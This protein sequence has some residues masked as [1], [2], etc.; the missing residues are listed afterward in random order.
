[1]LLR[2]LAGNGRGR[3]VCRALGRPEERLPLGHASG[4]GSVARAVCRRGGFVRGAVTPWPCSREALCY[5]STTA[6]EG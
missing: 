2:R 6:G 1:M 5:A 4:V 3:G